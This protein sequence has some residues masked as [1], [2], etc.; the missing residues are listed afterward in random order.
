MQISQ[1]SN[2][3]MTWFF[4]F[5]WNILSNEWM[6]WVS[7]FMAFHALNG[8]SIKVSHIQINIAKYIKW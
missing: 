8:T 2:L 7:S 3:R 5:A 4:F 6:M 1:L